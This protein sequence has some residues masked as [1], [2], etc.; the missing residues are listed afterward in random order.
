M[1]DAAHMETAASVSDKRILIVDDHP[2]LRLLVREAL[3]LGS[4]DYSLCEASNADDAL[5]MFETFRPQVVIL[6]IMLPGSMNGYRICELIKTNPKLGPSTHV[7]MLTAR[8][9]QADRE[10]G[11]A[12]GA[13]QYLVKPFSPFHLLEQVERFFA[14]KEKTHES[15]Q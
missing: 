2:E 6:D 9:Q 5:V 11:L 4:G 7:I 10:R 1:P 15:R 13:D 8:G 3:T 12:S 14:M